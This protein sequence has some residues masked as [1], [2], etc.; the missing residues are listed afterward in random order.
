MNEWMDN[1]FLFLLQLDYR[2]K[3]EATKNKWIWTVDR[4]D[5]V[6]NAKNTFQQSD[7]SSTLFRRNR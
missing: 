5:F 4:P 1:C 7:V 2:K 6:H 3:Y